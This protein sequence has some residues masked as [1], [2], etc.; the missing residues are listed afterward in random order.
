VTRFLV[1]AGLLLLAVLL[2]L[3]ALPLAIFVVAVTLVAVPFA[4]SLRAQAQPLP[5][6]ASTASR[7]PPAH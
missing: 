4:L 3:A 2:P 1:I 7:A 5:L 6:F